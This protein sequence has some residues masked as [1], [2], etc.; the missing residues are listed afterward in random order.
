[1]KDG[2]NACLANASEKKVEVTIFL[3]N[4]NGFRSPKLN[5]TKNDTL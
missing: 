2:E 5:E 1:M 3:L 4:E